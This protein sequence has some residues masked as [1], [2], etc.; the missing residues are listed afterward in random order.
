MVRETARCKKDPKYFYDKFITIINK[1]E[2]GKKE[3]SKSKSCN[4]GTGAGFPLIN[5]GE[6]V[7]PGD[8]PYLFGRPVFKAPKTFRGISVPPTP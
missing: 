6:K 7:R 5:T 4:I 2:N 8:H 3:I 1:E